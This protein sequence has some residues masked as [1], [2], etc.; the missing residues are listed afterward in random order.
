MVLVFSIGLGLAAQAGFAGLP[1]GIVLISWYFKY[2]Y[3]LFDAVVRGVDE[4]PVLDIQ[5]LNPFGEWR[6]LV[7]LAVVGLVLGLL[8]LTQV[9]VGRPAATALAVLACAA[10]PASVAVL[11]LEENVLMAVSPMHLA[12]LIK[13]LGVWYLAVLAVIAAYALL[14]YL[15]W[16]W[17]PWLVL[18]RIGPLVAI[19]S[20][21]SALGGAVYIRRDELGI[22]VWHSPERRKERQRQEELKKSDDVVDLAF[23]QARL[24]AHA[25]ATKI[26]PARHKSR[27]HTPDDYHWLCLRTASWSD[28]RHLRRLTADYV[29]RLLQL[30]RNGEALDLVG[31]RL[32]TDPDFRPTNAAATLTI[33]QLA[34]RGGSPAIAR[35]LLADFAVRYA[36]EPSVGPAATLARELG[37]PAP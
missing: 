22:E 33:A 8:E 2:I 31:Q 10:L 9:Y 29:D 7:Q 26:L 34:G 30:R 17:M 15:W 21:V 19:L 13:G 25:N 1:L 3:F 12:R 4:P 35:V 11:G 24:G 37:V 16:H 36:G 27:N 18:R 32:K 5:M 28:P 6:P 23:N 14:T 20:I